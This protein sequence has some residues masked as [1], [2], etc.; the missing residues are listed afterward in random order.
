[1]I[2]EQTKSEP[3]Q[4]TPVIEESIEQTPD[5]PLL[6]NYMEELKRT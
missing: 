2:A 4:Q 6:T 5:N 1:V 3:E